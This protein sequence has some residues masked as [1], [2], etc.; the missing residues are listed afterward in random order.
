ML[1][2]N[3]ST[4][5]KAGVE[6]I[7]SSESGLRGLTQLRSHFTK[8]SWLRRLSCGSRYPSVYF[9]EWDLSSSRRRRCP[10]C[11]RVEEDRRY[12]PITGWARCLGS[13]S[14]YC[15]YSP[16]GSEFSRSKSN[17]VGI[18]SSSLG[19]LLV[20]LAVV[21]LTPTPMLW[22]RVKAFCEEVHG[23]AHA[24]LNRQYLMDASSIPGYNGQ[25][26]EFYSLGSRT[27]CARCDEF[28][29]EI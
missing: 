18:G 28:P 9:G 21:L 17:L 13:A 24:W 1:L 5:T 11:E 26:H 6:S 14:I 27:W 15:N 8:Y 20:H 2:H 23:R 10:P 29:R 3:P 12:L 7:I 19:T 25:P 22:N 16:E 4:N